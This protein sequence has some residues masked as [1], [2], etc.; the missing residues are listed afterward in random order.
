MAQ[1]RGSAMSLVA[2][3]FM[4]ICLVEVSTAATTYT[5]GDS[6]GWTFNMV[7]WPAGKRFR[8]GDVLGI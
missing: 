5:V 1:G 2:L 8:A 3:V 4:M 6:S 7:S